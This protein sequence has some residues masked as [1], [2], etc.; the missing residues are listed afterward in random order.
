[1]LYFLLVPFVKPF[2]NFVVRFF[3]TR[4]TKNFTKDTNFYYKF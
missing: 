2:V 4:D 3:T 1:V